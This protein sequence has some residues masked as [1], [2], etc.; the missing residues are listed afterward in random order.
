MKLDRESLQQ[1]GIPH[2]PGDWEFREEER[3]VEWINKNYPIL[4][5]DLERF[6]DE[7]DCISKRCF[8]K[9]AEISYQLIDYIIAGE[10]RLTKETAEKLLP[11]MQKYGWSK[12]QITDQRLS[13][14]A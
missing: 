10:R 8:A 11:V 12:K 9:K 7:R 14:A 3:K 5:K 2:L 4:P 6:F 1:Q 13:G